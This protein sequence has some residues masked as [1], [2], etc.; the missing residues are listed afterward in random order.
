MEY[1]LW[2]VG[3]RESHVCS[4]TGLVPLGQAGC[5]NFDCAYTGWMSG[6][7][8]PWDT[9]VGIGE[10]SLRSLG[11]PELA[12]EGGREGVSQGLQG[13]WSHLILKFLVAQVPLD[14]SGELKMELEPQPGSSPGPKGKGGAQAGSC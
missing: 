11:Q 14:A 4:T 3:L 6:Y 12:G 2:T 13:G 8:K 10:S 7:G 5:R 9:A 1:L